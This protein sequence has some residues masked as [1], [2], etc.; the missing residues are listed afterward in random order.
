MF[1]LIIL[2]VV[3]TYGITKIN[4]TIPDYHQLENYEPPVTTRLFA[5][6]GQVRKCGGRGMRGLHEGFHGKGCFACYGP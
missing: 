6:D 5:G 2:I 4:I 1:L 3:I